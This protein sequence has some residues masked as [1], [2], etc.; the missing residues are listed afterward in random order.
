MDFIYFFVTKDDGSGWN[1]DFV[2]V[3]ETYCGFI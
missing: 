2:K 1:D 3:R